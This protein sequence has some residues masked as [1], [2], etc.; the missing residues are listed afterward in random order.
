MDA[1]LSLLEKYDL[2]DPADPDRG[3]FNNPAIQGLYIKLVADGSVSLVEALRVGVFIEKLDIEDLEK[4][5]DST[6][7]PDITTVYQNLLEGSFNH[8]A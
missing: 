5:L 8:L 2:E 1:V 4:F 3:D 6:D 7:N